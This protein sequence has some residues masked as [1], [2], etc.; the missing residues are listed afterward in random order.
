MSTFMVMRRLDIV[1][2]VLD[3]MLKYLTAVSLAN[4]LW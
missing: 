4:V 1:F 3:D 2:G